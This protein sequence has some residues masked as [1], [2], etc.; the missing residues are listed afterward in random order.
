MGGSGRGQ[1]ATHL[2]V[3]VFVC[4]RRFQLLLSGFF[5]FWSTRG[6]RFLVWLRSTRALRCV[7]LRV[8]FPTGCWRCEKRFSQQPLAATAAAV[9]AAARAKCP[10]KCLVQLLQRM[11]SLSFTLYRSLSADS[12]TCKNENEISMVPP[13]VPSPP[14]SSNKLA[15][16][17]RAWQSV[18]SVAR[19]GWAHC[20]P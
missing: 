12:L 16:Y 8:H 14:S 17:G 9:A 19:P 7:Q 13:F 20:N 4:V 2:C 10:Q 15:F 1:H 6:I 3:C 11:L 18:W 5:H